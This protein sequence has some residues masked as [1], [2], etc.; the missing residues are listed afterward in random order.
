[1]NNGIRLEELYRRER[2]IFIY[3]NWVTNVVTCRLCARIVNY[4]QSLQRA[5]HCHNHRILSNRHHHH[6][7]QHGCRVKPL[8]DDKNAHICGTQGTVVNSVA[9]R[10]RSQSA[11][12][13]RARKRH[14]T[15][16]HVIRARPE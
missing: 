11:L 15:Q 6:H 10:V 16:H 7:H 4:S 12:A 8:T 2:R 14:V 13:W 1:V 5:L 9:R 3:R